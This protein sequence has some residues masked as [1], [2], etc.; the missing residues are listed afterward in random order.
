MSIDKCSIQWYILV[1]N[2]YSPKHYQHQNSTYIFSYA[3]VFINIHSLRLP[4]VYSMCVDF[5]IFGM[6]VYR[7]ECVWTVLISVRIPLLW[8][9]FVSFQLVHSWI[10]RCR[11]EA[12][13]GRERERARESESGRGR[14]RMQITL[15]TLLHR[16]LGIHAHARC[17][18]E[19]K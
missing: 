5:V 3:Y 18:V 9:W 6:F 12:R 19:E 16:T 10:I 15:R 7:Y 11:I 17:E 2:Q 13:R 14:E 4:M 1:L 8:K